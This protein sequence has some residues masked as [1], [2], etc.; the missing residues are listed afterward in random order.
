[1]RLAFLFSRTLGTVVHAGEGGREGGR[2][3]RE[4][5]RELVT[6]MHACIQ[7]AC[8][9]AHRHGYIVAR[10]CGSVFPS[11]DPLEPQP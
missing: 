3:R 2:A 7:N 1:M 6:H 11:Q 5:E 8:A 4:A 9:Q 10:I